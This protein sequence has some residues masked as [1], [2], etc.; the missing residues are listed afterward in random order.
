MAFDKE[1][2]ENNLT[3]SYKI[4]GLSLIIVII[5]SIAGIL[6]YKYK[7]QNGAALPKAETELP[8]I[9]VILTNGCGFEGVAGDFAE[10]LADK[11]VDVVARGNTKPIYDKSIIVMRRG[12]ENDLRRL[13]Q[14]T[15]IMRFTKALSEFAL[16]DFEII[17]GRDYEKIIRK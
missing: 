1:R 14:M 3:R 12:D 16:G 4:L 7:F 5:V 13:Q 10:F 2:G 9:K 8:A 15:G 6:W 17:I 11:N